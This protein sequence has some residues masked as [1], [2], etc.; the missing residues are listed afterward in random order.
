MS[1][2][3]AVKDIVKD[4]EQEMEGAPILKGYVRTLQAVLKATEGEVSPVK[5]TGDSRTNWLKE[6][7][8]KARKVIERLELQQGADFS[9]SREIARL[10][11]Y[12]GGPYDG[13]FKEVYGFPPE[14]YT[15][16][17]SGGHNY[18]FQ[19]DGNLHYV[20]DK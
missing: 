11:R 14:G 16:T 4:M 13:D 15:E 10:V 7:Q 20:D 19:E 8:E 6:Q 3:D 5:T 2:R 18:R 1:L 12:I 17:V 9:E